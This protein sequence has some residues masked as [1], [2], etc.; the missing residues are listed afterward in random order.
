MIKKTIKYKNFNG[1]ERVQDCFFHMHPEEIVRL[2]L[3]YKDGL[4]A[5][6]NE[7]VENEDRQGMGDLILRVVLAS[8]GQRSEDGE[9]FVKSEELTG[10]FK[11]SAAYGQLLMD[12]LTDE[13]AAVA[14]FQ[15]V[16]FEQVGGDDR[17]NPVAPPKT[18]SRPKRGL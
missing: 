16:G 17:T 9:H 3:E 6:V 5:A 18:Q 8:Y 12:L 14:F 15:G 7:M 13:G 4:E 1:E 10:A 2:E 11:Q